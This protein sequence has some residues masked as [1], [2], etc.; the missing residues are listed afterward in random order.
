[1]CRSHIYVPWT[2]SIITRTKIQ[3]KNKVFVF[4]FF[5]VFLILS[6]ASYNV[7]KQ[8]YGAK[9]LQTVA[10]AYSKFEAAKL[11]SEEILTNLVNPL[12]GPWTWNSPD[13]IVWIG[14]PFYCIPPAWTHAKNINL[15]NTTVWK[16]TWFRGRSHGTT[17]YIPEVIGLLRLASLPNFFIIFDSYHHPTCSVKPKRL[18]YIIAQCPAAVRRSQFFGGKS[19][20]CRFSSERDSLNGCHQI[21]TSSISMLWQDL[22]LCRLQISLFSDRNR[23]WSEVILSKLKEIL[24][25]RKKKIG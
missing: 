6:L 7:E 19:K 18:Q 10:G 15:Y 8:I 2:M 5:L 16:K 3:V 13:P 21:D 17:P 24:R 9:I 14:Y 11:K 23:R 1:M 20:I 25:E 22:N 12:E 4:T